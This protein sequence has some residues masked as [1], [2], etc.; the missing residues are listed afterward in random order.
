[1]LF[2]DIVD[3]SDLAERLGPEP[4]YQLVDQAWDF[5]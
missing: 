3:S 2:C 5:S 4:M 1:V